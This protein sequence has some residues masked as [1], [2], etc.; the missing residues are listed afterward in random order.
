M[1]KF[2]KMAQIWGYNLQKRLIMLIIII[3]IIVIILLRLLR[4]FR[5]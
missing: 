3:I 1:K 2:E 5:L 4:F